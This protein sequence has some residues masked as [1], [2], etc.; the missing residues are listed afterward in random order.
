MCTGCMRWSGTSARESTIKGS[1]HQRHF[2]YY[3]SKSTALQLTYKIGHLIPPYF[4]Y[5][6]LPFLSA[7]PSFHL[8][9]CSV[10]KL[11]HY[12]AH[13]DNN[14]R[15]S[16]SQTFSNLGCS[17]FSREAIMMSSSGNIQDPTIFCVSQGKGGGGEVN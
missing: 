9:Y 7:P 12:S 13:A 17:L 10:S 14:I 16:V 4:L 15:H 11:T 3:H 2:A 1:L 6:R 5:R 8:L